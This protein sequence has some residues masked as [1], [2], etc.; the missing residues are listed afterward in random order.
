MYIP[1]IFFT[2]SAI[3]EY[4]GFFYILSIVNSG[5]VYMWKWKLSHVQL[6]AIPWTIQSM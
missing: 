6:F 4:L 2:H 1:H 5:I 3:D